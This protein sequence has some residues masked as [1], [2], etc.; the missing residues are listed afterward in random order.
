M[1]N[2]TPVTLVCGR[3]IEALVPRR[4]DSPAFKSLESVMLL[5]KFGS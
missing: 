4:R 5:E 3:A 2:L 1:S